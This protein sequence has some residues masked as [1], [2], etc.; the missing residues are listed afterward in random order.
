M[1]VNF[2][3]KYNSNQ[4]EEVNVCMKHLIKHNLL[5]VITLFDLI[6][7]V[8]ISIIFIFYLFM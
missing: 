5:L 3:L 1:F 6:S 2:Y 8:F 4:N 7:K